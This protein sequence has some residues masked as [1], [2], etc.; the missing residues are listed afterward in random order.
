M[1]K[2]ISF[3]GRVLLLAIVFLGAAATA[4]AAPKVVKVG[5][6]HY[7]GTW[8]EIGRTPMFLT[9]G[10][11]AGYSTYRQGKTPDQV[12]VEDGCHVD[13]PNGRLKTVKGVGKIQDFG[14]T[15]AKMR[16]R[17]PLLITFNYWVLYK[18]PDKSWF[19]SANPSMS[20]LWIY[21]RKVPSKAK[22][23]RMIRK[24]SELGY[25]VRKLEFPPAR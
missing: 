13:T 11:V 24:A 18:A 3:A 8:L 1:E 10:C 7:R 22:L 14:S 2:S 20:D 9:N 12:L 17:Y 19:I 21:A 15:N 16:V 23:Q 4:S 6:D 5:Q 25:D